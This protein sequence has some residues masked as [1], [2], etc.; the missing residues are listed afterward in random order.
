MIKLVPFDDFFLELSWLWL[1]DANLR[2]LIDTPEI[3]K[4]EQILWYKRLPYKKD[5]IIKGINSNN[6]PIGVA[7]LK[8]INSNVAE[9]F[10][11]IGDKENRGKGYGSQI[12]DLIFN[13]A[14]KQNIRTVNLKVIKSN[15]PAIKL[16]Q[17]YGFVETNIAENSIL[18]TKQI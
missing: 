12:L 11:Y 6:I 17:K 13:L 2:S 7:G 1:Q 8:N 5:Y 4:A 18:M 3:V 14:Q 15:I 10:G 16:Y 9:Y